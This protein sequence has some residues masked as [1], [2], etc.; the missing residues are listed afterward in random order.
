MI[1]ERGDDC[2]IL[3]IGLESIINSIAGRWLSCAEGHLRAD[4]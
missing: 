3:I 1:V 2:G 4:D